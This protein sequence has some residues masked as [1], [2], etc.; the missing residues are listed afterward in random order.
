MW[1]SQYCP[2]YS[3][4]IR[5]TLF[6]LYHHQPLVSQS[7]SACR[8]MPYNSHDLVFTNI[9]ARNL[10]NTRDNKPPRA[11]V[12]I[13]VGTTTH[14]T[15][16]S[17]ARSCSPS[18]KET[19][20]FDGHS[21]NT[22]IVFFVLH[23][24]TYGVHEPLCQ[25]EVL[26]QDFIRSP[27]PFRVV[28]ETKRPGITSELILYYVID[29]VSTAGGILLAA[30]TASA[31]VPSRG[32]SYDRRSRSSTTPAL[33]QVPVPSLS[34]QSQHAR[35]SIIFTDNLSVPTEYAAATANLL[36][37]IEP[38]HKLFTEIAKIHPFAMA[39]W[40]LLSSAYT[41]L[42][43]ER[44]KTASVWGLFKEMTRTY[45][46]AQKH[47]ILRQLDES[48]TILRDMIKQTMECAIFIQGYMSG[49]FFSRLTNREVDGRV[50]GFTEV[51][52]E[53]Q[54]VLAGDLTRK[55]TILSL[56]TYS[57][58]K[59]I[60]RK[61][62]LGEIDPG[63]QYWPNNI[64][65][66]GTRRDVI[67]KVMDWFTRD[68][69]SVL[70][71]TGPLGSGKTTVAATVS[72]HASAMGAHGRLAAVVHFSRDG[73]SRP[74][75]ASE[76][77]KA[78]AFRLASFD[79]RI[80]EAVAKALQTHLVIS[81]VPD[82]FQHLVK[83]PLLSVPGLASQG[84]ILI[85]VDALEQCAT[86]ERSILLRCLSE[87][88][89]DSLGFARLLVT[90]RPV[91]D[92]TSVF[93]RAGTAVQKLVL[94][95]DHMQNTQDVK[96]YVTQKLEDIEDPE[97]GA[98]CRRH[99]AVE[100][101]TTLSEGLFMW[102]SIS[103][104]FI[105]RS[106]RDRLLLILQGTTG[107]VADVESE[108]AIT[109]KAALD[110]AVSP[111]GNEVGRNGDIK[112]DLRTFLGAVVVAQN[113]PGLTCD[114]I[115][116]LFFHDQ[117]KS[118]EL[119][120]RLQSLVRSDIPHSDLLDPVRF[121]HQSFYGF[122]QDRIRADEWWIDAREYHMNMTM[123]CLSRLK[124]YLNEIRPSSKPAMTD[125]DESSAVGYACLYWMA[126]LSQTAAYDEKIGKKIR[127]FV[128]KRCLKWLHVALLLKKTDIAMDSLRK[129]IAWAARVQ[130]DDARFLSSTLRACE[131]L[132]R[133]KDLQADPNV[134][135]AKAVEMAHTDKD[136][137]LICG[138][139]TTLDVAEKG[140]L[141][142]LSRHSAPVTCVAF[143]PSGTCTASASTGG[144]IQVWETKT[145]RIYYEPLK[146]HSGAVRTLVFSPDGKWLASGSDDKSIRIRSTSI[147]EPLFPPIKGHLEPVLS[148][149]FS[150]DGARLVSGS[151]DRM[152][153]VW[154]ATT[155]D[156][157][158]G[159]FRG[160]GK[161]VISVG[162]IRSGPNIITGSIDETICIWDCGRQSLLHTSKPSGD[163][164]GKIIPGIA[165][166]PFVGS[167]RAT[168]TV[169][170]ALSADGLQA[171]SATGELSTFNSDSQGKRVMLREFARRAAHYGGC[172]AVAFAPDG[173]KFVAGYQDGSMCVWRTHNGDLILGRVEGHSSAVLCV[174]FSQDGSKVAYAGRDCKVRIWD[175]ESGALV[176]V[177]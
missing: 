105:S 50:K 64:Y 12:R 31:L 44:Q 20:R 67:Q 55:I 9:E 57:C 139:R 135:Y 22:P 40:C 39:A 56:E 80:G 66:R 154:D 65:L 25:I 107:Q 28:L 128:T 94:E 129:L 122:L 62:I 99:N 156:K 134:I 102:A 112:F 54:K 71:L 164:E 93:T 140:K 157:I 158:A 35:D 145:G 63:D 127:N 150:S 177:R 91:Q 97:F 2:I 141:A 13:Q 132:L 175:V 173:S 72:E 100:R 79:D 176:L 38:F 106:P 81:S 126:H 46:I 146:D 42:Q 76:F 101:L 60:E 148:L 121:L 114:A 7:E 27:C 33:A 155:G 168:R 58:V 130:P 69:S 123:S 41:M 23:H 48:R 51:F 172:T 77:V 21:L 43:L 171:I 104:R 34:S 61:M 92:I 36:N 144:E 151:Q 98:L 169:A 152:V 26:L 6:C 37:T 59:S 174:A 1:D 5:Y 159:P 137:A 10:P 85:V 124:D 110:F 133:V 109:Y 49:N 84:P 170:L 14:K 53:L 86:D 149:A 83:E 17:E 111:N 82:L 18:W 143:S 116:K 165:N 87:G 19:I 108:L 153:Y 131:E 15:K 75:T 138:K 142:G 96:H 95:L 103:C 118:R 167:T 30:A 120:A 8:G 73:R 113:P 90:S 16:T 24:Q 125:A 89:G 47:D 162:F 29:P 115:D 4:S 136:I 78:L 68:N 117:P 88:L 11:F 52:L 166:L 119:I 70:W 45:R 32:P 160:H 163:S 147:G 74:N 161:A 3:V